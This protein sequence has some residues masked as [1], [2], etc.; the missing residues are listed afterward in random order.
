MTTNI[1]NQIRLSRAF[2]MAESPEKACNAADGELNLY[3]LF[4]ILSP[5]PLGVHKFP[6]RI[7]MPLARS[8]ILPGPIS[9]FSLAY[10]TGI[11]THF[12]GALGGPWHPHNVEPGVPFEPVTPLPVVKE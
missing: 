8:R 9:P 3:S 4:A 6:W 7:R 2:I 12:A 5:T 1:G 11:G 10:S